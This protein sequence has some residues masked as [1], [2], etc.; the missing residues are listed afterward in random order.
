LL[1]GDPFRGREAVTEEEIRDLVAGQTSF[2]PHQRTIIEGAFEVAER[3]LHEVLRPRRAVCT[4]DADDDCTRACTLLAASGHSRAPVCVQGNLDDV[5][6][7]VHL[8]D[9]LGDDGR[10][11]RD[12]AA[13][14]S[15]V[16][17]TAGVLPTLREM[18]RQHSQMV[19]VVNEHGGAE[20][21][22]TVEDLVEEL[23]GEVYDETDRDIM[24]V[25]RQADGTMLIPGQ[26]P[27]HDLVD[28]GIDVPRGDYATLAGFILAELQRIPDG[29]GDTV[30]HDRWEFTV[31]GVEDRLITEVHV[32]GHPGWDGSPSA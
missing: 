27:V 3:H 4:I 2:T 8:R 26:F 29:P 15:A 11:V 31:T 30:R 32:R 9:L 12:V 13:P 21:I 17:E 20:G 18:Q 10:V 23:V 24:S 19:V 22:V 14:I 28:L 7:V 1:G 16:P 5:I 6:G 25:Q